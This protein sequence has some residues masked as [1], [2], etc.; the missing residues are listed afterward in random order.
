MKKLVDE[1]AIGDLRL[2]AADFAIRPNFDPN[3]R[4][5]DPHLG[6]GALLDLGV[7]TISLGCW[8]FGMPSE[9]TGTAHQGPTGVDDESAFV[10]RHAGG[11]FTLGYQSLRVDTTREAVIRGTAGAIRLNDPWWGA[12]DFILE[13][14][15]GESTQENF[16]LR[17]QGYTHMAEAF[18]DLMR[19]GR[20]DN[21][22]IPLE[23]S[24]QIMGIM[25]TL[26]GKWG[27][28]YP[29]E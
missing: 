1:G 6:G 13:K 9:I 5:F 15:D 16:Q 3:S 26:R 29:G 17:G 25:D 20:R 2:L 22:V 28:S 27:L 11:R 18:M 12:R 14:L 10:L 23:E 8:L 21:T 7:Y 4:L 24:V 19:E